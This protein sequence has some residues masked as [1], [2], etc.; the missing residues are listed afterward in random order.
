MAPPHRRPALTVK[1]FT[2]S[3]MLHPPCL[4]DILEFT[5]DERICSGHIASRG[6][7]ERFAA[8]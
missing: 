3:F 1:A 2:D 8:V 4:V 7:Y 6:K 5:P